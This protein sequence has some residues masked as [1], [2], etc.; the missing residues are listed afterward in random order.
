MADTTQGTVVSGS[1]L[2]PYIRRQDVFFDANNLR[3]QKTA[4]LFLDDIVMNGFTQKGNKIVLNSK[5]ILTVTPNVG[6]PAIYAGDI[7]YQGSSNVSPTFTAVVDSWTAGNTTL[8]IKT[9]SGNFDSSANVFVEGN[10]SFV[11]TTTANVSHELNSNTSDVFDMNEGIYCSN[12]NIFMKVVGSSGENL[13]Y[14]SENFINANVSKVGANTLSAADFAAGELVFQTATGVRNFN[15]AT[16]TAKVEWYDSANG[17]LALTPLTGALKFNVTTTNAATWLWSSSNVS[18]KIVGVTHPRLCDFVANNFL[19]ST[20]N[21]SRHVYILSHEHSSGVVA[22]ATANVTGHD[23]SGANVYLNS[24]NTTVAVGTQMYFTAG[25][26][27]GQFR[28]VTAVSGK[29]VTLETALTVDP[30]SISKYSIGN[31][32]VD[33]NGSLNGIINIPEEPNFK[34]KTGD[35]I[36]TITDTNSLEDSDY[37]MKTAAR[38]SSGGLLN[39]MEQINLSQ[40]AIPVTPIIRPLP[41]TPPDRPVVPDPPTVQPVPQPAKPPVTGIIFP[42]IPRFRMG[43]PIAQTFTTPRPSSNKVNSGTFVTSID[44]FFGVKPN[45]SRGSMQLPVTVKIAEVVNGYPTQN[46]LATSTVKS[47]DVKVSTSPSISNANSITK[48]T[49]T[50][51]VYLQPSTEYAIVIYSD[52]PEYEVYVAELGGNVLG[53]DPPQ[54]ISEQPY[55]GSFFR[56][57]NSSTWTAYQNEDLMF[58]IN[59]AVFGGTGSAVFNIKDAPKSDMDV[60]RLFINTNK[61]TFPVGSVDFKVK[62]V[63]KSNSTYDTYNYIKPQQIFK[64]GSL[65]DASN[66]AGSANFMNTRKIT[67][68]NSNSL[69]VLAEFASSDP[70]VSPIF[71]L[72]TIGVI[73]GT[74]DIN[75]AGIANTIISITNR[76]VGYN[77]FVTSGNAVFG[78]AN[79]T[80]NNAA[81]LY[82]ETYLANNFN[83]GFYNIVLSGNTGT[84]S[85]GFA[86]ANT[87]GANTVDYIVIN[88]T[89]SG[90]VE[91]PTIAVANG[92]AASG[93][94]PAGLAIQGETSKRGGNIRC[95]YLTRQIALEDGFESGDL[96]V[97]MDVVRPNGTDVEVYYKV[98]GSED[99]ETFS[100]KSWV[101]MFKTV[102][103]KS[104]DNNTMI[105]LEFRP[106]LLNNKLKYT[107]N[108]V[109]YPIGGKFKYFAVKVCLTAVDSTIAP[110]VQ[111]L[112][113]IST[114]EG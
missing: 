113:V 85:D 109:Q 33:E 72:E 87:S 96:R 64:Y 86:V 26:G 50:D 106:D 10:I 53:A 104:K 80:L 12:N 107:E 105:E 91:T 11:T 77:A 93:M 112:R 74:H 25:I 22:N 62:G 17:A 49:F 73:A 38:F 59:K 28:R 88:S 3:P 37:T 65:L 34:F 4:R 114:P 66:K 75:D 1:T 41:P 92:N 42:T 89:G 98:L 103:R 39:S 14:V 47:K 13:L 36:F 67:L 32:V 20:A 79:S 57:Q 27:L 99:P 9:M 29:R 110:Y 48:F 111:N 101:R 6:S 90:Y 56:S 71:N 31:F 95:K 7:V 5:K 55:S 97:F 16:F 46:Y 61:L 44:L 54:R 8:V 82:R 43:D 70:D 45:V 24:T 35:R 2:I 21:T 23:P 63:F 60:D 52:S 108:G 30:T 19:I 15:V 78:S 81:Q 94:I 58:V 83:I 68:G 40:A 51:P 76:G 100:D 18:T 69:L 102:D 84:G